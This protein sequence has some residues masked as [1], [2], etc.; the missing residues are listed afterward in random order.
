M[1]SA[2]PLLVCTAFCSKCA[3]LLPPLPELPGRSCYGCTGWCTYG[4]EC[5][6]P[7]A[8]L[9]HEV[10]GGL[11]GAQGRGWPADLM[12]GHPY[13]RLPAKAKA[14]L[15]D[16]AVWSDATKSAGLKVRFATAAADLWVR[17]SVAGPVTGD[18]LWPTAGHCGVDIYIDAAD[19]GALP[20]AERGKAGERAAAPL[21]RP[22]WA[23]SSGNN[24]MMSKQLP[25]AGG[26]GDATTLVTTLQNIPPRPDGAP[27][28][29][30]VYAPLSCGELSSFAIG[31][32]SAQNTSIP[33]ANVGVTPLLAPPMNATLPGSA[34]PVLWYGTSIMNGAAANRPGMGW[35][36]QAERMLGMGGVNLGFGGQGKMQPGYILPNAYGGTNLLSE[37]PA[38]LVV[39]DC[40]FNMAGLDPVEVFN[41]T[42]AFVKSL[43]PPPSGSVHSGTGGSVRTRG[44]LPPVL[45]LEGH[46]HGQ[47]W[48]SAA[49]AA[50]QNATREAFR[51]A[52]NAL[53]LE[54]YSGV[55]Y[56]QGTPK[57]RA[58]S[59]GTLAD[60]PE[61]Q[62][63]T[64]AGVHPTPLGLRHVAKH[65]AG[66]V[67]AVLR[68]TARAVP[69]PTGGP[70]PP[71]IQKQQPNLTLSPHSSSAAAQEEMRWRH[72][73][74]GWLRLGDGAGE[75][76]AGALRWVD[77]AA[78]GV[79]GRAPFAVL[80]NGSKDKDN[81]FWQRC[82]NSAAALLPKNIWK[83]SQ[84][85]SGML[86]RFRTNAT[87]IAVTVA[88]GTAAQKFSANTD[89]IFT[90][91]G[92]YGVDVYV[93]DAA[94]SPGGAVPGGS[95]GA[96]SGW[97]WAA[98]EGESSAGANG[99]LVMDVPAVEGGAA[100]AERNFTVYLPVWTAV[101]DL[102]IGV[103]VG[104]GGGGGGTGTATLAPLQPYAATVAPVVVWGS[105]IAQGGVV[106]NAGMTWPMALQR[107]LDLP[108]L[109]FGFSGS[110]GMQQ[111]VATVLTQATS[112]GPPPAAF[113][114]DCLPN[115][116]QDSAAL[117]FNSTVA[118]LRQLR[119]AYGPTVPLLVLEGHEYT[120][121][122]IK[123]Q[124]RRNEDGLC[125]AQRSAFEAL[126]SNVPNLH[127]ASST[128]KLGPDDSVA[129]ESTGGIG[130][131]P[132]QL[133][134]F[135]MA[136]FA[137]Q[138]LRALWA[139][140]VT[141]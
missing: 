141:V 124:Q 52:Y 125:A 1:R 88:R 67:T 120:T 113:V 13:T 96:R 66:L 29:F 12:G 33:Q 16:S 105:S 44:K 131:H 91:N 127:Y 138:K 39:L 107:A 53:L 48:I 19:G 7:N 46:D 72:E 9:W 139:A 32:L 4:D 126:Q 20:D 57:L 140:V 97:R 65:V 110:C 117:V 121:N 101:S 93:Q 34:L 112:G 118:V 136:Q 135:H 116:Q 114:M 115:M 89:D 80:R 103:G 86:V 73:L 42:V 130:V 14:L 5:R 60:D 2:W 63:S 3:A 82:P 45:L 49:A 43:R 122:W 71:V 22:R 28:H 27:R 70:W 62:S 47:A 87:R 51:R 134:H 85:P 132:T 58:T 54:G 25:L 129:R 55:Y 137:A 18:W 104:D 75:V 64:C 76:R 99:S 41:R 26:Q 109:N 100:G 31:A 21:V 102:R 79:E 17:T 59:G 38:S 56:G 108:V 61:A 95:S 84:Q 15:N 106:N 133:A 123:P 23:T 8:T 50:H 119:A 68:G 92:K 77:G 69:Q 36:Q 90:T 74:M 111:S 78:L 6:P 35:P 30:T 81:S 40:E 83:L 98:T 11:G 94:L 37:V 128:G 10:E 24:P